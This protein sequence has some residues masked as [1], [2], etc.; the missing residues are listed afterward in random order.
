M[1][2]FTVPRSLKVLVL[3]ICAPAAL[4]LPHC[5]LPSDAVHP[6]GVALHPFV[7]E[8]WYLFCCDRFRM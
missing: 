7:I 8:F 5:G 4:A 1:P 2:L 6:E 3:F